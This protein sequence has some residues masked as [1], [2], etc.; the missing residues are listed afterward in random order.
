MYLQKSNKNL[1]LLVISCNCTKTLIPLNFIELTPSVS[2]QVFFHK[3]MFQPDSKA[4]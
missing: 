1:G 3:Q 4:C 2:L